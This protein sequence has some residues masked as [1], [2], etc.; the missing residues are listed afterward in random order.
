[1]L[2]DFV[3]LMDLALTFLE[4]AGQPVPPEMTG[5]S[6]V[7]LLTGTEKP[8]TRQTV[9]AER[10]RHANVRR[11]DLSYPIRAIRTREYLYIRNFRPELWPAGD[12]EKWKAVGP[13]GD[14][15]DGLTKQYIL[16]HRD[17]P[18]VQPLFQLCF[19]KRPAEELYDVKA[20]P[21]QIHNLAG[22]P[23]YAANQK[24]LR[25][26]LDRWMR[27]PPTPAPRTPTTTAGTSIPTTVPSRR[28]RLRS[29]NRGNKPQFFRAFR[30]RAFVIRF[31]LNHE[32]TKYDSTK[33][34]S[35]TSESP[36]TRPDHAGRT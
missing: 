30:F 27:E 36:N 11:G 14:C 2:D 5:R 34:P 17:D 20:D 13:F 7:G 25:A 19:G 1:M 26:D 23:A 33:V 24:K 18:A 15:D 6:I 31:L 35:A 28:G 29:R 9:F 32:N 4:A 10:E 22:Q 16:A 12:P 3:N 21:D 8:G